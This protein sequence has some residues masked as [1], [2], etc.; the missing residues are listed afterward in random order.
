MR[1]PVL[2]LSPA[3]SPLTSLDDQFTMRR[4]IPDSEIEVFEGRGHTRYQDE[5]DRCIA[6]L[7]AFLDA[8]R[9]RRTAG[10]KPVSPE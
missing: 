8:T 4:T 1:V 5:P 7:H 2:L 9:A 10:N 3:Q 6:R